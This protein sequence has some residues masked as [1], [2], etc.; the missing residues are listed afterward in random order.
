MNTQIKII[1]KTLSYKKEKLIY[2]FVLM[3]KYESYF[4]IL[5]D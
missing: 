3:W 1:P 5:G 2:L 4:E